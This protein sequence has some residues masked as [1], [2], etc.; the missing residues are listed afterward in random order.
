MD[1]R[2]TGADDNS[3]PTDVHAQVERWFTS[4][5]S[6]PA[7]SRIAWIEAQPG[8]N[9]QIVCQV[10]A[11]L[12]ADAL[13]DPDNDCAVTVVPK[14]FSLTGVATYPILP[15]Y[16]ILDEIDRGGMGVVYRAR[17]KSPDRIVAVKMMKQGVFSSATEKER[18]RNE[19]NA[20]SQL[21]H[22]AVVPIYEVGEIRGEPFITMKFINGQTF[23][24]VLH[25]QGKPGQAPATI[26]ASIECL[27]IVARA[28]ANAHEQGIIHRDLKPSN[29]LIDRA[30]GQPWITD[31]G[32]ARNVNSDSSL[33]TAGDIIGTPGYMA[34]EQALGKSG[35]VTPAADV[36][37]LGAILYRILT[38]RTPIDVDA[39]D[40]AATIE[41]IREHD[42][43]PPR[44]RDRRISRELSTV[45]LKALETNPTL[46]YHNAGELADDLQ[47][48]LDG[49]AIQARPLGIVRK[50]SRWARHR[51]GLTVTL[52]TVGVFYLYHRIAVAAGMLEGD[53]TFRLVVNIIAPL[54]VVNAFVWQIL[55]RRT[56]G[57]AWT[58]YA[59]ATGEVVLLTALVYSGDGASSGL[60]PA[61]FLLVAT[62][63]LRCRPLLVGYVT[64][65]TM[66]GFTALWIA[67]E[68]LSESRVVELT[69]GTPAHVGP[70]RAI[71][72]L[73]TLFL[74]GLVQ[75]IA[76]RRSS[77]SLE[78][79]V[80]TSGQRVSGPQS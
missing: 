6:Q 13:C 41:R 16:E 69:A 72:I 49:E 39:D 1:T 25:Q 70:L 53:L 17:Q 46:R 19:A 62:S 58:L 60:V 65:L 67:A 24:R 71:P 54:A 37:G 9:S 79:R 45:C 11:A 47:R 80:Q 5:L 68:R 38:G 32:L 28:I 55:L 8:L 23:A 33:T 30:T 51:P 22:P 76:L 3:A 73:L 44:E 27:L 18:F 57:A 42:V 21:E 2:N 31:F 48:Y 4:A 78:S 7:G 63:V 64:A 66:L 75:F 34:P 77:V 52:C 74:V 59:W 26:A 10:V 14:A 40:L 15:N 20:A 50:L 56:Q 29:I 12:R 35:P 36:Y 61:Y 43:V